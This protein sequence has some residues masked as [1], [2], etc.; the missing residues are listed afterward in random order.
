MTE[1]SILA[2][3]EPTARRLPRLLPDPVDELTW[4]TVPTAAHAVDELHVA[5][6]LESAGVTD[7]VAREIYGH[8]DVFA[9]AEAVYRRRPVARR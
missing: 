2:G 7:A 5:A 1:R 9:L 6:M 4:A 3:S 8:R